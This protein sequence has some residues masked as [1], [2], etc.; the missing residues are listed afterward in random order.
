MP[1]MPG[2]GTNIKPPLWGHIYTYDKYLFITRPEVSE[3]DPPPFWG[4]KKVFKKRYMAFIIVASKLTAFF[5]LIW[6][7]G[8]V[9]NNS[10]FLACL[11]VC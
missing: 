4:S 3:A 6:A 5:A 10:E 1:D 9:L 7:V 8:V 2:Q 11:S